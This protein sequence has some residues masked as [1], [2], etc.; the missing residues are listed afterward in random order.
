MTKIVYNDCYGGFSLSQAAMLRYAEIKG[1]TL[2]PETGSF[3]F[4]TYWKVPKEQRIAEPDSAA[5]NAG[6]P[7]ERKAFNEAYTNQ[8]LSE[9]DFSRTDPVLAQVVEELREAANGP[10]ASL[11]IRELPAGSSYRIDEYDGSESVMTP[12]DYEW[13]IA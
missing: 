8:T 2:Y 12:E 9:R 10:C 13:S 5:W 6:S 7:E 1:I 11:A 3:G 4:F